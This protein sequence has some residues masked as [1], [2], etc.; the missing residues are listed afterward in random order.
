MTRKWLLNCMAELAIDMCMNYFLFTWLIHKE[1]VRPYNGHLLYYTVEWSYNFKKSAK[2]YHSRDKNGKIL[3]P[4]A[5]YLA[6][7]P[8]LLPLP[9]SSLELQRE[10]QAK[11]S[12]WHRNN[13][14]ISM[15]HTNQRNCVTKMRKCKIRICIFLQ[16]IRRHI[17]TLEKC[18]N[19]ERWER[20][21][22]RERERGEREKERKSLLQRKS[23]N[24][25]FNTKTPSSGWRISWGWPW[26]WYSSKEVDEDK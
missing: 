7:Q 22:E 3:G 13:W 14:E 10:R 26:R 2:Y 5:A 4:T 16:G 8:V 17:F 18:N 21:R 23:L 25:I 20:E 15:M 24:Q 1:M 9:D 6:G 11:M 12:D 19:G